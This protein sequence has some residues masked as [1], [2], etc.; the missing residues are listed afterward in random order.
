MP[1]FTVSVPLF[2]KKYNSKQK[3]LKLEQKAIEST[4]VNVINQLYTS[5]ESSISKL[6]SAKVSILTQVENINE[7]E[8]V[9]KVLLAG[10][11][12]SEIDFEQLLE[13]QQLK[14]KFQLNKVAAEK[15]Y[16]IQKATLEFLTSNN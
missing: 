10:Y 11:Q 14:L 12:T 5:F 9:N 6:N 15:Q 3:Q 4:K 13:V 2:S 1:M 8:R 16:A 7:A